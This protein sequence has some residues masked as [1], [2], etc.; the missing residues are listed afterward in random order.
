MSWSI[1]WSE[2]QPCFCPD[3]THHATL[4]HL[5][6]AGRKPEPV[7]CGPIVGLLQRHR[8]AVQ[9]PPLWAGVQQH[10]RRPVGS[11]GGRAPPIR[12][13]V[14]GGPGG[15]GWAAAVGL[16]HLH[17]VQ[18]Q[19][20]VLASVSSPPPPPSL[21]LSFL[22]S[23]ASLSECAPP[24][25]TVQRRSSCSQRK[26]ET[27]MLRAPP[28]GTDRYWRTSARRVTSTNPPPHCTFPSDW[29]TPGDCGF[30]LNPVPFLRD[31]GWSCHFCSASGHRLMF[32]L[33]L[34]LDLEGLRANVEF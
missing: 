8:D 7:L 32:L 13:R 15:S 18:G 28:A 30:S 1:I 34:F 23:W 10:R 17:H 33:I 24:R 14:G 21:G 31:S 6:V 25:R 22:L 16:A 4:V 12:S 11:L 29:V 19:M 5:S 2:T 3:I 27:L 26:M 20:E 9:E